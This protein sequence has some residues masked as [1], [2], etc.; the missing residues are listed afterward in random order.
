M[1]QGNVVAI[2]KSIRIQDGET[3]IAHQAYEIGHIQKQYYHE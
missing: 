2:K 1:N 3:N